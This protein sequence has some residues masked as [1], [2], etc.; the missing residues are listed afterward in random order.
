[1]IEE[2]IECS[3][4]AGIDS[5]C[6]FFILVHIKVLH[7]RDRVHTG[8]VRCNPQLSAHVPRYFCQMCSLLHPDLLHQHN[9]V[10][11]RSIVH[12]LSVKSPWRSRT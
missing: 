7:E 10:A 12:R 3:T 5:L 4:T 9:I 2:G 1:M 8:F 11:I 6:Q